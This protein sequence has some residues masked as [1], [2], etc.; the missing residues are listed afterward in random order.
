MN[1]KKEEL[2]SRQ[3][4]V[5]RL[6]IGQRNILVNNFTKSHKTKVSLITEMITAFRLIVLHGGLERLENGFYFNP[7]TPN[8]L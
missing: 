5:S 3:L 2:T 8:E 1:L 7:L 6:A 4:F